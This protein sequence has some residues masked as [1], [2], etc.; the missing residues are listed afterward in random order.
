MDNVVDI[1]FPEPSKGF[2][3]IQGTK[4]EVSL[5]FSVHD[6]M[7]LEDSNLEQDDDYISFVKDTICK[8]VVGDITL[9]ANKITEKNCISYIEQF[10]QA[11]S[12]TF[13][14]YNEYD[15]S[16]HPCRRF[17]L[18]QKELLNKMVENIKP[19]LLRFSEMMDKMAE[20]Y[21]KSI[22]PIVEG[23]QSYITQSQEIYN[24]IIKDLSDKARII[25]DAFS[26]IS[27][28]QL[29]E[30]DKQRIIERYMLWGDYGWTGTDF[31]EQELLNYAPSDVSEAHLIAKKMFNKEA[32]EKL[33]VQMGSLYSIKKS[34]LS[35]LRNSYH[36]RN[37]KACTLVAFSMIDSRLIRSQGRAKNRVHGKRGIKKLEDKMKP[38]TEN[39][40]ILSLSLL[41]LYQC[42]YKMFE[43]SDNFVNQP[44]IINRHFVTHGMLHRKVLQRDAIQTVLLVYN[45]YHL[46]DLV[47]ELNK[48]E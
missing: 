44:N 47:E 40:F 6:S 9:D 13:D 19:A 20:T 32:V 2:L 10:L 31:L 17:V 16:L 48:H 29:S 26:H 15:E 30:E 33:F 38:D 12:E 1:S 36:N 22:K 24:S 34:D 14:I 23:L 25:I 7:R 18:V 8:H 39:A 28:P 43:N 35:E 5:F 3:D 27:I 4:Y 42:L 37:Y 21:I 46:T 11:N 41:N 45:L